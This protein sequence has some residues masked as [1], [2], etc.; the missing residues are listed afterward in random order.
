MNII[1]NFFIH[2]IDVRTLPPGFAYGPG[3]GWGVGGFYMPPITI[4]VF[5]HICI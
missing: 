5:I 4:N 2:Y 3:F 1:I